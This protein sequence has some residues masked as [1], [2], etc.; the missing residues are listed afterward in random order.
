LG[1]MTLLVKTGMYHKE[2]VD[3][4]LMD[5]FWK[6]LRHKE[7]RKAFMHFAR[8][9]DN[10]NLMEIKQELT[11]VTIPTLIVRGDADSFLESTIAEHLHAGMPSSQLIRIATASHFLMEDEPQWLVRH[12]L[13]FMR[14]H[15]QGVSA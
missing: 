4:A 5:L 13:A 12:L 2:L 10:E 1:M 8:C 11:Q 6:P 3:D 14:N 9:L 7:G 15:E